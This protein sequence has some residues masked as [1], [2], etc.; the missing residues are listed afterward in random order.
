MI[1]WNGIGPTSARI[2]EIGQ[3]FPLTNSDQTL[4]FSL[5]IA[6][7][8]T[9]QQAKTKLLNNQTV[10]NYGIHLMYRTQKNDLAQYFANSPFVTANLIG[11]PF[12]QNLQANLYIPRPGYFW[13]PDNWVKFERKRYRIAIE[14]APLLGSFQQLVTPPA[15]R[16][17][18]RPPRVTHA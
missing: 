14:A 13:L 12:A 11:N 18:L 7:R 4:S 6:K 10:L 5:A 2:G 1:D 3:P 17:P 16:A 9:D 8:D 15:P